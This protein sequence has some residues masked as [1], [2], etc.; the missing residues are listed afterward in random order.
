MSY[1]TFQKF[2]NVSDIYRSQLF[3]SFCHN[4][5]YDDRLF[6][7]EFNGEYATHLIRAY[8]EHAVSID[9]NHLSTDM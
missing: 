3:M 9:S 8:I 1:K 5:I 2:S 4:Y 6:L 7:S